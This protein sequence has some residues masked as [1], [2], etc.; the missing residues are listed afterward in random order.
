MKKPYIVVHCL[1][2][3][4]GKLQGNY[5]KMPEETA[6]AP[7]FK[8][9]GFS[10]N[11]YPVHAQLSGTN[12]CELDY[13]YGKVPELDE[14]AQ[15]VPE[16][17][18]I[19]CADAEAYLVALDRKGKL[20]WSDNFVPYAGAKQHIIAVLSETVTNAY[21]AFLRKLGISYIICGESEIDLAVMC[22]KLVELFGVR[23]LKIGGGGMINWS[24]VRSGL[25]DEVS[26]V[27]VPTADG[28]T[29]TPQFF[30]ANDKCE[31]I[32]VAFSLIECKADEASGAVWLRYKVKKVWGKQEYIDTFGL[33]A[34]DF[35]AED[36]TK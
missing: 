23:D 30:T 11:Y 22:D 18:F 2:S 1:S 15:L 36:N 32:P 8:E 5:M 24:F 25:V 16:G 3:M 34:K 27:V 20:G 21:K 10:G 28:N 19:A 33:G 7:F 29:S 35:I 14:N 17:D 13:T 6:S 12:T 4:D 26:I 31:D 9:I